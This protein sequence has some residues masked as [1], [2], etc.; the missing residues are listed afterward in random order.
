MRTFL[1]FQGWLFFPLLTLEGL[2]LHR[3]A[4]TSS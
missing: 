1:R 4:V 3:Y 2:N